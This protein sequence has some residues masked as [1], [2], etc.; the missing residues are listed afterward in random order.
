MSKI[1]FLIMSI[2]LI[3]GCSSTK[4]VSELTNSE[5][6][7]QD[8][9]KI[10]TDT[11][12]TQLDTLLLLEDTLEVAMER[13]IVRVEGSSYEMPNYSNKVERSIKKPKV[14]YEIRIDT[15]VKLDTG[16]GVIT[17]FVPDTMRIDKAYVVTLRI[18][19]EYS[20]LKNLNEN[21]SGRIVVD[22]IRIGSTMKAFLSD[23]ESAFEVKELSTVEQCIEPGK[24][25]T[26][27][28][29]SV[30]PKKGGNKKMKI[31][32]S[33][34]GPVNKDFE[35]FSDTIHV[36]VPAGY[37]LGNFFKEHWQWLISTLIIP[38]G[39]W[40]YNRRKKKKQTAPRKKRKK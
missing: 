28:Q 2:F 7:V 1:V 9:L 24:D 37:N 32:V 12:L 6:S 35:V 33:M 8:T 19:N 17:Y 39:L 23:V 3:L 38:F 10:I 40:L 34:S 5:E 14:K 31:K 25:Y 13:R 21:Q 29:W 26:E 36:E 20:S 11:S 27:W 18:S 16:Y 30:K 22:K 4:R 15:T